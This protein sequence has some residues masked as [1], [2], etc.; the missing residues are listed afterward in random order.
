MWW[1]ELSP[2]Y[3][4]WYVYNP[5]AFVYVHAEFAVAFLKFINL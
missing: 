2:V 3:T 1:D 5:R 4:I